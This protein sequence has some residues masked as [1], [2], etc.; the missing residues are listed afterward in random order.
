MVHESDLVTL[1]RDANMAD[2]TLALVERMTAGIFDS[3]AVLC[4]MDYG[5]FTALRPICPR[6]VFEN[7]AWGTPGQRCAGKGG[8]FDLQ[9]C[10]ILSAESDHE[11]AGAGDREQGCIGEN[12]RLT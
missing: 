6:D 1:R 12:E 4:A 2:P 8:A 7:L 5:E 11:F 9:V 3:I 10:G